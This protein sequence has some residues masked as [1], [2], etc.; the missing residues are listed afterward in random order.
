MIA[1]LLNSILQFAPLLS[2]FGTGSNPLQ[3]SNPP[4]HEHVCG[5]ACPYDPI[6]DTRTVFTDDDASIY[7]WPSLGGVIILNGAE[8]VDFEFLD[9]DPL[10]PPLRRYIPPH[11]AS[12]E[13]RQ[14]ASENEDIF[15]QKILLLGAKW[16][17]S[18]A[19]YNIVSE[20]E[21]GAVLGLVNRRVDHVFVVEDHPPPTIREKRWVKVGWPSDGEGAWIAEFDTT[22]AG[23]E[24]EEN[25]L[26]YDEETGQLR[27][28][29]TMDERCE[30]LRARFRARFYRDLD[31]EYNGY[32]FFHAWGDKARMMGRGEVGRLLSPKETIELWSRARMGTSE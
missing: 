23:V 2:V 6:G 32:G 15:C 4:L 19:R 13:E 8:A 26:P 29:R 17:D 22:W 3:D 1:A 25:L 11:T 20:V 10:D 30:M 28:A 31:R 18:E 21:R 9:L 27:M 12:Q 5:M 16:W 14:K 24:E 7:A